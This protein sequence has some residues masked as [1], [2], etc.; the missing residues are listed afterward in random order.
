MLFAYGSSMMHESS[1]E[2]LLLLFFVL[3]FVYPETAGRVVS[4]RSGQLGSFVYPRWP[5]PFGIDLV[6]DFGCTGGNLGR[7]DA[8]G[9]VRGNL[10]SPDPE[11]DPRESLFL[12]AIIPGPAFPS[13]G[14]QP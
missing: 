2:T 12:L 14:Y 8:A 3:G 1:G 7:G 10:G 13:A 4:L 11:W 5:T 6:K 9:G